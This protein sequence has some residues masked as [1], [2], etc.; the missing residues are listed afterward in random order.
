[1]KTPVLGGARFALAMNGQAA[2]V[3]L[4]GNVRRRDAWNLHAHHATVLTIEDVH[5]RKYASAGQSGIPARRVLKNAFQFSLQRQQATHGIKR[6]RKTKKSHAGP[7][8]VSN[9]RLCASRRWGSMSASARFDKQAKTGSCPVKASDARTAS[10]S[11]RTTRAVC[12]V[13]GKVCYRTRG[14]GCNET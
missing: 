8:S 7:P 4:D 12:V 13:I 6:V 14:G 9:V 3:A 2:T 10:Q 1:M 5:C 11:A